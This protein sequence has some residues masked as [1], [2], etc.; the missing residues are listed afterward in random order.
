MTNSN[1]LLT[2]LLLEWWLVEGHRWRTWVLSESTCDVCKAYP[3]QPSGN[4]VNQED[5]FNAVQCPND[6]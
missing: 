6:D 3:A 4:V 1:K 5:F 2:N